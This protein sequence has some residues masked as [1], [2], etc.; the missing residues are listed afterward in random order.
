[1]VEAKV[2]RFWDSFNN[3][4]VSVIV[5]KITVDRVE[6]KICGEFEDRNGIVVHERCMTIHPSV[7]DLEQLK[8]LLEKVTE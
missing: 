1:M 8:Q 6:L 7:D 5:S 4:S 2:Y 3:A